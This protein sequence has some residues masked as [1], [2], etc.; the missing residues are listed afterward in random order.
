MLRFI[1]AKIPGEANVFEYFDLKNE[2][3]TEMDYVIEKIIH[4]A[5]T[6]WGID[7]L[8]R[9]GIKAAEAA[10]LYAGAYADTWKNYQR[11]V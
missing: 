10:E 3:A 6:E 2:P 1:A 7:L 8:S 9:E 11:K 5:K 4:H